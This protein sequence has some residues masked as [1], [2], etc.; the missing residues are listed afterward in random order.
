MFSFSSRTRNVQAY[1]FA[2]TQRS[3]E[4]LNQ[5]LSLTEEERADLT[6]S[7]LKSLDDATDP[8]AESLWQEEISRRVSGLDSGQAKAIP[9]QEVRSQVSTALQHGLKK[10]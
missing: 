7:L 4:L 3:L 6:A 2:M 1:T 5:A 10:R 9:W 8:N